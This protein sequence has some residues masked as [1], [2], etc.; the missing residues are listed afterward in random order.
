MASCFTGFKLILNALVKPHD[1][2]TAMIVHNTAIKIFGSFNDN[3]VR[4]FFWNN[5]KHNIFIDNLIFEAYEPIIDKSV[6]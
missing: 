2:K 1:V 5:G 3:I 6:F 4:T